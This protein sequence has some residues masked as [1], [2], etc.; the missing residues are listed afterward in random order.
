MQISKILEGEDIMLVKK[1]IKPITV[2]FSSK[3]YNKN[4]GMDFSE[5]AWADPIKRTEMGRERERQLFERFGDVGIGSRNPEPYPTIEAYGHRFIPALFGCEIVYCSDQA[6]ADIVLE[7]NVEDVG[8]VKVP[9]FEKS[10]V[11]KRAF[12]DIKTLESHYGFCKGDINW[13]SPI[14]ALVSIYGGQF[15]MACALEPDIA[16]HAMKILVETF[17]KLYRELSNK[18]EPERF[19][20]EKIFGGYG[21][22]PAIMFSPKM[23]R[24]VVLPVDKI[25]RN[26]VA[27]FNLHHCGIFDKYIDIYKEI[28]PSSLDIGGGSDYRAIRKAFPDIPFSLIINAPDV[29]GKTSAEIDELIGSMAEA[30]GPISKVS[31]WVSELSDVASDEVIRTL[32]TAHERI[33]IDSRDNQDNTIE[34]IISRNNYIK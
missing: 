33:K 22:C 29:E 27:K 25:Y 8:K 12:A 3:W 4:F 14:N 13:G 21:N 9:D 11:M 6:P 20:L 32:A 5:S 10:S 15:P 28:D 34:P 30:A 1:P 23:Y 18:V 26:R 19:P 7:A 31:M 24:D 17:F 16:K 2:T